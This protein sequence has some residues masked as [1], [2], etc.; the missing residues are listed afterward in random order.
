MN[1]DPLGYVDP[2]GQQSIPIPC[3][4]DRSLENYYPKE[5]TDGI[6]KIERESN[7]KY[8]I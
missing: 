7:R 3:V 8:V 6:E 1:G 4:P 5:V 2:D